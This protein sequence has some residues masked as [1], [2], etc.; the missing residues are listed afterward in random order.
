MTEPKRERALTAAQQSSAAKW[1]RV[2]YRDNR[3][4]ATIEPP[5]YD[6]ETQRCWCGIP[7]P[8]DWP[9]KEDGIPHPRHGMQG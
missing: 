1:R 4:P 6:R 2:R 7:Y 3:A 8:H 5:L 9:G